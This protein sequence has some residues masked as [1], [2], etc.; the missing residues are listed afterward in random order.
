MCAINIPKYLRARL[1]LLSVDGSLT[2][3]CLPGH[4]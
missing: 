4:C 1:H 3:D 2:N